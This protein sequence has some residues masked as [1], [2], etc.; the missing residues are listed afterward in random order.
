MLDDDDM[1][2]PSSLMRSFMKQSAFADL[3]DMFGQEHQREMTL[4]APVQT[5]DVLSPP[6]TGSRRLQRRCRSLR[7]ACGTD[8]YDR[9]DIRADEPQ[10]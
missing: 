2:S 6:T 7:C 3:S 5:V 9:D 4:H 10:R 1:S 8:A